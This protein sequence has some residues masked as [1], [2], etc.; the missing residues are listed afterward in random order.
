[1][2]ILK[3]KFSELQITITPAQIKEMIAIERG[4][5][6]N[7]T[8][9]LTFNGPYLACDPISFKTSDTNALYHLF[10]TD[11]HQ[12]REQIKQI[13]AINM[14]FNVESDPFNLLCFWLIHLAFLYIEKEKTRHEFMAAVCRY[15]HYRVFTSAINNSFRNGAFRGVMDAAIKS[16]SR[17]P[18]IVRLESWGAIIDKHVENILDP[19]KPTYRTLQRAS[20]DDAFVDIAPKAQTAI[21]NKVVG[22]AVVYYDTHKAG[23]AI[24]TSSSLIETRDGERIIAQTADT[25]DT[26]MNA[27]V[28]DV[29]SQH[30]WLNESYIMTIA[31][32][33]S[34]ISPEMLRTALKTFSEE[35]ARQ[36]RQRLLDKTIPAKGDTPV[37]YVGIRVLLFEIIRSSLRMCAIRQINPGHKLVML[38]E[39]KD[40]YAS[41]RNQD[42]DVLSVKASIAYFFKN[43]EIT[44]SPTATSA[45]R[46][47]VIQYIIV[48]MLYKL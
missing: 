9:I 41:S 39:L 10:E 28:S 30:T 12:I 8:N 4:F 42:P 2:D 19:N 34:A 7:R 26:T 17:K 32:S 37:I 40:A 22:F 36:S 11:A 3:E 35:A 38:K 46:L 15:F 1:M 33:S 13:P 20:P 23:T 44:Y 48:K 25:I 24:R 16:M 43:S 14:S 29:L 6:L 21:R 27:M 5:R 31:Q 47:A 45:I 18:D